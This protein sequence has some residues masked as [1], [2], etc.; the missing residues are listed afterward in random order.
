MTVPSPAPTATSPA[1]AAPAPVATAASVITIGGQQ[2]NLANLSVEDGLAIYQMLSPEQ[3]RQADTIAGFVQNHERTLNVDIPQ[4]LTLENAFS[5][6]MAALRTG[7]GQL[8]STAS[9]WMRQMDAAVGN[10]VRGQMREQIPGYAAAER[11]GQGADF[12]MQMTNTAWDTITLGPIFR[13]PGVISALTGEVGGAI[14]QGPSP[15]QAH[16]FAAAYVAA[17]ADADRLNAAPTASTTQHA[18]SWIDSGVA[19]VQAAFTWL[20]HTV[21]FI[22][23]VFEWIGSGFGSWAE[24]GNRVR[25]KQAQ[26]LRDLGGDLNIGSMQQRIL[27]RNVTQSAA[28]RTRHT[29]SDILTA[30]GRV[31]DLDAAPIVGL[32]ANGGMYQRQDGTRGRMRPF[33][34]SEIQEETLVNPQTGEPITR[35]DRAGQDASTL[36]PGNADGGEF[37]PITT[38]AGVGGAAW[39]AHKTGAAAWAGRTAVGAVRATVGATSGAASGLIQGVGAGRINPLGTGGGHLDDLASRVGR[40]GGINARLDSAT[41]ALGGRATGRLAETTTATVARTGGRLLGR[42]APILGVGIT[43]MDGADTYDAIQEG[44]TRRAVGSGTRAVTAVG[45]AGAGALIGSFICPGLGTGAGAAIGFAIGGIAS[46]FTGMGAEAAY[47]HFNPEEA[48]VNP[49]APRSE[50]DLAAERVRAARE[51][52]NGATSGFRWPWESASAEAPVDPRAVAAPV[53]GA[54]SMVL[55]AV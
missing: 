38:A 6:Y 11:A 14:G 18:P 45:G 17:Q 24:A 8:T 44:D 48:P 2:V 25:E 10:Q 13:A 16:A 32:L 55:A 20:M 50:A 30:A 12:L 26:E 22:P 42:A 4:N 47:D 1:P 7:G 31:A 28:E 9:D 52:A 43:V 51:Q 33:N 27:S 19:W 23:Q 36:I 40:A 49:N 34:G 35:L 29:A 39:V 53:R 5:Q 21:P 54:P 15:E 41:V 37:N 46:I 3:K